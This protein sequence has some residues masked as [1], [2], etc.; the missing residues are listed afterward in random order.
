[1][2]RKVILTLVSLAVATNMYAYDLKANMYKLK[3]D[4]DSVTTAFIIGNHDMVKESIKSL[5]VGVDEL[6]KNEKVMKAALPKGKEHMSSVALSAS[7]QIDRNIEMILENINN[8]KKVIAQ[9]AALEIQKACMTCHNI[10]R[11]R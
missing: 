8:P 7:F 5:K 2:K 4:L 9:N 3:A 1:M 11:D 6:L 10:V